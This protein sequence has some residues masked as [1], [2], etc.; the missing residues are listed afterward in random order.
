MAQQM[1]N[2]SE[3]NGSTTYTNRVSNRYAVIG[4]PNRGLHHQRK[5]NRHGKTQPPRPV[6]YEHLVDK[7]G[8][9]TQSGFDEY[10]NSRARFYR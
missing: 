1:V 3:Y 8:R 5:P 10:L 9:F 7:F 2:G 6:G 4:E